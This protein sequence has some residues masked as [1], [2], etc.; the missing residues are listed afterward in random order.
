MNLDT[1]RSAPQVGPR[2]SES[3]LGGHEAGVSGVDEGVEKSSLPTLKG[4]RM[5]LFVCTTF[6][7][8]LGVG[9]DVSDEKRNNKK[10]F[11]YNYVFFALSN[12]ASILQAVKEHCGGETLVD[13]G[14]W[15]DDVTQ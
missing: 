5:A 14:V 6:S 2:P 15:F 1:T 11:T 3:G 12:I 4:G 9:N 10:A 8:F 7:D 13:S